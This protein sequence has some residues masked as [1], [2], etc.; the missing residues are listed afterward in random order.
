MLKLVGQ[1]Y[2]REAQLEASV[3][4]RAASTKRENACFFI[5]LK[6][7]S[8]KSEGKYRVLNIKVCWLKWLFC[9]DVATDG[10]V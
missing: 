3:S 4:T 10:K 8:K 1:P 2:L 6:R 5:T 9:D 7:V